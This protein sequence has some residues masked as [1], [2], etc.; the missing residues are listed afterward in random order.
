M[1]S[2]PESRDMD[3]PFEGP[4]NSGLHRRLIVIRRLDGPF[5]GPVGREAATV[6]YDHSPGFVRVNEDAKR[7]VT[8]STDGLVTGTGGCGMHRL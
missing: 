6:I 8:Q 3:V 5:P 4:V 7:P 2:A 1:R